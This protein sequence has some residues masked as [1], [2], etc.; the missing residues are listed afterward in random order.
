MTQWRHR[1]FALALGGSVLLA[2]S[3][4]AAAEPSAST[5][6]A[7]SASGQYASD[8]GTIAVR[9]ATALALDSIDGQVDADVKM[10]VALT[11][12]A[13]PAEA[14]MGGSFPPV[15]QMA[16]AGQVRGVMLEFDP[17]DRTKATMTV[18]AKPED[19]AA[20]LST[21][22]YSASDGLWKSLSPA[23]GHVSG[24]FVYG[25]DK[26]DLTFDAPVATNAVVSDLKGPAAQSSELVTILRQRVRAIVDGDEATVA[27]LS[28]RESVERIKADPA[29]ADQV[30]AFAAIVVPLLDK[31]SR[32]VVR[33]KT[34]VVIM[35]EGFVSSFVKDG[36]VWK[37]AD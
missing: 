33:E 11:D 8:E 1:F 16:K 24:H 12:R 20:S 28:T 19:P 36:G 9:Y 15:W 35:P 32:V 6:A 13:V 17:V 29:P 25:E 23:A 3:G 30:K 21:V 18:L 7:S 26:V 27:R 14:L 5:P 4:L 31:V 2:G 10:R 34:A 22:S 37:C